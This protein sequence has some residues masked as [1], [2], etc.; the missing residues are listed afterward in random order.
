M[1][2][3][4]KGKTMTEALAAG[5]GMIEHML[6]TDLGPAAGTPAVAIAACWDFDYPVVEDDEDGTKA[7]AV[8]A[9]GVVSRLAALPERERLFVE[10]LGAMQVDKPVP[11]M[12]LTGEDPIAHI[13]RNLAY[14]PVQFMLVGLSED[15]LTLP[16][17][18]GI[19]M[20]PALDDADRVRLFSC[21]PD[22]SVWLDFHVNRGP[23]PDDGA[24]YTAF[25]GE[26]RWDVLERGTGRYITC[27]KW[28][29]WADSMAALFSAFPQYVEPCIA[30]LAVRRE[31]PYAATCPQMDELWGR[32]G[33]ET[34]EWR[35]SNPTLIFYDP[36]AP[37]DEQVD[38]T[39]AAAIAPFPS[40]AQP[41]PG[42]DVPF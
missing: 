13:A 10:R 41:A 38:E 7:E 8:R 1:I 4:L 27:S 22:A 3:L 36:F 18:H 26:K 17:V 30:A 2:H 12:I 32:I 21:I 35:S 19:L 34:A 14:P 39:T 31:T 42:A 24:Y 15:H 11:G 16:G 25:D 40:P 37:H 28:R 23:H 20:D 33:E 6:E 5:R 9:D 29:R